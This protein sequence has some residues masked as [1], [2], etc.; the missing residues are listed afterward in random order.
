[1]PSNIKS[2]KHKKTPS[3]LSWESHQRHFNDPESG[4]WLDMSSKAK[5]G[6]SE[7]KGNEVSLR[8]FLAALRYPLV[9]RRFLVSQEFLVYCISFSH[10]ASSSS[11]VDFSFVVAEVEAASSACSRYS[12]YHAFN[13]YFCAP[14]NLCDSKLSVPC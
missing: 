5:A 13:I 8:V 11:R 3:E 1:M 4:L 12:F 7:A 2:S 6:A 10:I 14:C 9:A